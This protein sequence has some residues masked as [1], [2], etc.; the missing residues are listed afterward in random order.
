MKSEY[1]PKNIL[2]TGSAG[3]IGS[4]FVRFILTKYVDIFAWE[5]YD[6]KVL[7]PQFYHHGIHF[8][9]PDIL[10]KMH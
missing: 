7:D 3:F 6:T 10:T 8:K 5:C 9:K 1:K 4:N 2:V